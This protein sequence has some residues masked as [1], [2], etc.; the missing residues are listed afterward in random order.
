MRRAP[1]KSESSRWTEEDQKA[2]GPDILK[3]E[4][5]NAGVV[6]QKG[7]IGE[8]L[9]FQRVSHVPPPP[10]PA[11]TLSPAVEALTDRGGLLL[12][13]LPL[14]PSCYSGA[15]CSNKCLLCHTS[16]PQRNGFILPLSY[17]PPPPAL[18]ACPFSHIHSHKHTLSHTRSQ[19]TN[20]VSSLKT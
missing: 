9:H 1:L 17:T 15:L 13:P 20:G 7:G 5:G 3:P 16:P 2:K 18:A 10:R 8:V 6:F 4:T 19:N 14:P 11:S 12:P